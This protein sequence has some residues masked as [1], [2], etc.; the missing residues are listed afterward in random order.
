[1]RTRDKRKTKVIDAMIDGT[2]TPSGGFHP[3]DKS[4][5]QTVTVCLKSATV[6]NIYINSSISFDFSKGYLFSLFLNLL[7][8]L[9]VINT[10]SLHTLLHFSPPRVFKLVNGITV[11]DEWWIILTSSCPCWTQW[12][13]IPMS[14]PFHWIITWNCSSR[15]INLI[16]FKK[17]NVPVVNCEQDAG[18]SY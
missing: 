8:L 2:E 17:K 13:R 1:M 10:S 15:K 7:R 4:V 3:M 11:K 5:K 6:F 16:F 12:R 18:L 14:S 9:F